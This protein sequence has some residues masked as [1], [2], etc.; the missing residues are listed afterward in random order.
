M[1]ATAA[2]LTRLTGT[3]IADLHLH[4]RLHLRRLSGTQTPSSVPEV[5]LSNV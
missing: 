5:L 1:L 2:F 3:C 4:E